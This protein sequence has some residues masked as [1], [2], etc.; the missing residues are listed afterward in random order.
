MRIR[1]A[2]AALVVLGACAP[3]EE[4]A[5][6]ERRQA[7]AAEAGGE[8]EPH[9]RSAFAADPAQMHVRSPDEPDMHPETV[10]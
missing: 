8:A 9:D 10:P 7:A 3:S 4:R 5:D 2:L 6:R 1:C